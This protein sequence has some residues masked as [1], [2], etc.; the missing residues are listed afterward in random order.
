MQASKKNELARF[1]MPFE[2]GM[3]IGCKRFGNQIYKD[4]S[5]LIFDKE[6]YRY[7]KALSDISGNDIQIHKDIPEKALRHVRNWIFKQNNK[8]IDSANRIWNSF[9]QFNGDF[10]LILQS[11]ELSQEDVDEMP[12]EEHRNYILQWMEG[13]KKFNN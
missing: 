12:W 2:L 11:D 7:Q 10:Y 3:D 8:K 6:H 9:N 5:F 1:N 4:K 13:R